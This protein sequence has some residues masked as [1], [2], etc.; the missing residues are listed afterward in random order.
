MKRVSEIEDLDGKWISR[1]R[2]SGAEMPRGVNYSARFER[3]ICFSILFELRS[4]VTVRFS[5]APFKWDFLFYGSIIYFLKIFTD[6][7]FVL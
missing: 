4:F 3:C 7:H 6:M 1:K 5:R 2:D